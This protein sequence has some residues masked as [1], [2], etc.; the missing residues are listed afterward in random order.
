MEVQLPY[1]R[2]QL[3]VTIPDHLQVDIIEPPKIPAANNPFG[4]VHDALDNLLGDF[5][6]SE[7]SGANSVAIAVN[8]KTRPVPHEHLL[9]PLLTKLKGLGI[10]DRAIKI[11][12]AVGTHPPM[13]PDEFPNILPPSV[14]GHYEIISHDSEYDKNLIYLGETARSTPIWTNKGYFESDLKIVVGNIA[15]HQ[16]MGFSGG[17]K[18]AAIGLSG[19][20]TMNTN[21]ALMSHPSAQLGEYENNPA[22]QDVEDIGE[23]VGVHL[24]LNAILNHDNQ[25]VDALA[26]DPIRVMRAG[27]PLAKQV[28]LVP[29]A[30]KYKLTISSPGGHPKDINVYQS[31]K[32][33]AHAAIITERGGPIILVAACPE[34]AGSYHYENW[35]GGKKSFA[36]VLALF[37]KES[38]QISTLKAYL[39]ARDASNFNLMIYSEL[40]EKLA[41]SL[42]LNPVKDLQKALNEAVKT[43]SP[44]ERIAVMPHAASTIPYIDTMRSVL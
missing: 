33:L 32:G 25:I 8:D 29:I 12:I 6:W 42:L 15:P 2:T 27:V 14:L 43:L 23:K 39:V 21:H 24:A 17:V 40:D 36:E 31:Q 28:S 38:V 41:L 11:F 20:K 34:G 9:P 18:S 7:F 37:E 44:G 35:M 30:G 3:S 26:G 19:F 1:G 10:P 4:M 5:D 16:F 22:R 13:T